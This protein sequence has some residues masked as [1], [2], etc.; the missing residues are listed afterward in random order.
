MPLLQINSQCSTQ[1]KIS[2]NPPVVVRH[3]IVNV[4]ANKISK[5]NVITN[6]TNKTD[7]VATHKIKPT[8]VALRYIINATANKINHPTIANKF[9]IVF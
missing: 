8:I 9:Q 6:K 4:I 3:F 7:H 2:K 5:I 1:D